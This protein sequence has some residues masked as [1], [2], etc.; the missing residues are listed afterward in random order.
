MNALPFDTHEVVKELKA[1]GFTDEQAEAVTRVVRNAQSVDLSSL[2]TK[3]DLSSLATK[4]DLSS[5]ATKTDLAALAAATK[6]DLQLGLAA[7]KSDLAETKAE[8]LKWM[9][10][11]IGV[12]TVVIVGAVI[13]L[14][15]MGRS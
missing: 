8:I 9:V 5:L 6:T 13:A 15:R 11:A 4:T 1:A 14:V 2:A 3:A 10:S 12:Q 7:A